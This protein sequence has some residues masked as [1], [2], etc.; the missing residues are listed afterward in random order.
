MEKSHLSNGAARLMKEGELAREDWEM[1]K[2]AAASKGESVIAFVIR[3][4]V[5]AAKREL[6]DLAQDLNSKLGHAPSKVP[7][8][9]R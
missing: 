5:I 1:V 9:K 3:H 4:A 6:L 2:L 8:P 7:P